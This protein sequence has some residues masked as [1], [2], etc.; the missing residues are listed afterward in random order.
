MDKKYSK[1]YKGK[2]VITECRNGNFKIFKI[3][4]S[5][6]S[7]LKQYIY[8]EDINLNCQRQ[9]YAS[10][11]K[12]KN[13]FKTG[14]IQL[15]KAMQKTILKRV[16][17]YDIRTFR[18]L[19]N[20]LLSLDESNFKWFKM[21]IAD[22]TLSCKGVAELF[23][24]KTAMSGWKIEK[25]L[26]SMGLLEIKTRKY[27]VTSDSLKAKTIKKEF[28]DDDRFVLI[29]KKSKSKVSTLIECSLYFFN[30]NLL[31]PITH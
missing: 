29:P 10:L 1:L 11:K 5:N 7:N 16:N 24:Y 15:P 27:L 18:I 4:T 2:E 28:A 25:Q 22:V 8:Y 30:S 9:G 6:I 20:D 17:L 14:K 31:T 12:V 19:N 3:S 21:G 23:G 26:E 13:L